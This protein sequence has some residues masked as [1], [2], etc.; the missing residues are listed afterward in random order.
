MKGSRSLFCG[1]VLALGVST[2]ASRAELVDDVSALKTSWAKTK[3]QGSL[4]PK[5]LERGDQLPLSLPERF[6][7]K[8][9]ECTSVVVLSAP[10]VS[11]VLRLVPDRGETPEAPEPSVAGLVQLVRCGERRAQLGR[12]V[13]EM[14]SPR[15]VFEVLYA[16]ADAPLP[17][18]R[19]LL[20]ARDPG[21]VDEAHP[22]GP[23][24]RAETLTARVAAIRAAAW[25]EGATAQ[26]RVGLTA[27]GRGTGFKDLELVPGCYRVDVL[28]AQA[29]E[30]WHSSADVDVD[31]R[32]LPD[33][34]LVVSDR[35][36]A[37]DGHVEL[38]TATLGRVRL[39]YSG[40]FPHVPLLGLVSRF[41]FPRDFPRHWTDATKNQLALLLRQKR[42]PATSFEDARR[43]REWLGVA[44]VT[45]ATLP[46]RAGAC[47][48]VVVAA[49]S[50]VPS[51]FALVAR[52]GRIHV[53]NQSSA[54]GRATFVK[55]CAKQ[56][57]HARLEVE[58]QGSALIW[59]MIAYHSGELP[60]GVE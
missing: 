14:R 49:S 3:A 58:A 4:P 54:P 33:G 46:T 52:Q 5:L 37:L 20:D 8:R 57:G 60:P 10:S 40:G 17:A 21:P 32:R 2:S 50:G 9:E 41:A 48:T 30:G 27:D 1:L 7:T 56:S 13:V 59:R 23:P 53:E 45:R 6:L 25:R 31:V 16:A 24:A 35:G 15:G 42:L 29:P 26:Q 44:G 47:Y 18:A 11:F 38:C 19:R 43:R 34:A 12:L 28:S 51:G 39:G 22:I 36:E 55:F